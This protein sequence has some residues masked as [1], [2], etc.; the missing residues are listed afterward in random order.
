MNIIKWLKKLFKYNKNNEIDNL[1]EKEKSV[2]IPKPL[3]KRMY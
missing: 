3:K 1:I 2:Y